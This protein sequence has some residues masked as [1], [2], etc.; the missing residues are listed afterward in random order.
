MGKASGCFHLFSA[1]NL[2]SQFISMS[3]SPLAPPVTLD[4]AEKSFDSA[5][6]ALGCRNLP[7]EKKTDSLLKASRE[8][9]MVK[10]GRRIPMRP[11][12]DGNIIPKKATFQSLEDPKDV[13][14]LSPGIQHCKRV[15]IADC[16]M[17]VSAF[18]LRSQSPSEYP[19]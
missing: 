3:G 4:Q 9:F 10:I 5:T 13:V 16:Q 8:D 14:D 7:A 15:L 17:D 19:F 1:E 12:L 6:E 11:I 18:R 2:Y